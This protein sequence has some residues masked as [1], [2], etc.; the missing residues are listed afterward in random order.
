MLNWTTVL[1]FSPLLP[2][3]EKISSH[4]CVACS[5]FLYKTYTFLPHWQG[6]WPYNTLANGIWAEV[7]HRSPSGRG[8]DEHNGFAFPQPSHPCLSAMRTSPRRSL[9]FVLSLSCR[10]AEQ[11]WWVKFS[12]KKTS[13]SCHC[14]PRRSGFHL[15]L[16]QS[17]LI[18]G[19]TKFGQEKWVE[20]WAP[21]SIFPDL[22]T[23]FILRSHR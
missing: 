23:K 3:K 7:T 17:W 14:I 12:V 10:Q 21:E 22:G 1:R 4:C 8:C 6:V 9:S 19:L 2:E 15:L 11:T 5:P 16:P 18:W 20:G 13:L